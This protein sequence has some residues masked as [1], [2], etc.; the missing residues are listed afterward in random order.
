VAAI[1]A[2]L[3]ISMS[4]SNHAF[5]VPPG[6]F[7]HRG[8]LKPLAQRQTV[9]VMCPKG[10]ALP[11]PGIVRQGLA[12]AIDA[13]LPTILLGSLP[14]IGILVAVCY[15]FYLTKRGN[16]P[17]RN[18]MKMRLCK[19]QLAEDGSKAVGVL[20]MKSVALEALL[21]SPVATCISGGWNYFW[22]IFDRNRQPL[23]YKILGVYMVSAN[24]TGNIGLGDVL[25]EDTQAMISSAQKTAAETVKVAQEAATSA[26][27][28]GSETLEAAKEQ[29]KPGLDKAKEA[30]AAAGAQVKP[31]L[32]KA[33]EAAVDGL[34][35]GKDALNAALDSSD[36]ANPSN[37]A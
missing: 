20:N 11:M 2:L 34:N 22:M 5:E 17:G 23:L 35:K 8:A 36:A 31:A 28:T 15:F 13:F 7:D 10:D 26:S 1:G 30:A 27:K 19:V 32:E 12:L 33:K 21:L 37:S 25:D 18:L 14:P 3:L 16:T 6:C 29:A 24:V 4:P 9:S